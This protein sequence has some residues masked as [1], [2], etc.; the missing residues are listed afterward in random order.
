MSRTVIRYKTDAATVTAITGTP[1]RIWTPMVFID[2]PLRLTKV[3]NGDV[4]KYGTEIVYTAQK[5]ARTMLKA[6][7]ALGITKGA[8]KFLRSCK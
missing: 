6:G 4:A 8:K 7:K 3:A 2:S 5:A 1:G